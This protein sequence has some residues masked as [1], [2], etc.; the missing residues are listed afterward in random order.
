MQLVLV[1]HRRRAALEVADVGAVVGDDQRPLELAGAGGIDPEVG[2]QLHR[3]AHALGH[4]D[5]A[6]VR[7]D[8]RIERREVVVALRHD[9]AQIFAHQLRM[10]ADRLGDR[11]EDDAELAQLRAEGGGDRDAVEH[12]VDRD[13]GQDLLL[14]D[15]DAQLVVGLADL[16]VDLVQRLR[17]L[18]RLGGRVVADRLVVDRREVRLLPGR[19]LHGQPAPIGLQPPLGHPRRLVLLGRDQRGRRPRSARWRRDPHRRR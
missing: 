16:G 12:V 7:E 5:E 10:L 4:V 3:A 2:R 19:L 18:L 13:A 14:T 17:P 6:A 1:A 11:A 8:G 15:R 9:R